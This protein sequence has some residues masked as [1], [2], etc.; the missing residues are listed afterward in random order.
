MRLAALSQ[1]VQ[2]VREVAADEQ[3][4]LIDYERLMDEQSPEHIPGAS[5]FL[6]HVH[7][8]IEGNRLLALSLFDFLNERK[9][10][11]RPEPWDATVDRVVQRVER[12]I[13]RA[14]H[15]QALRNLAKVLSWAGKQ[16]EANQLALQASSMVGGDAETAYLAGN[17]LLEAGNTDD[18]IGKFLEAL[19]IDPNHVMSLNS[20]GSAYFRQGQFDTALQQ[21]QRVVELQ[22]DFS[23]VHNNLGALYEQRGETELAI[24]HYEEAIRLNPRYSKAYNNVAVLLRKQRRFDEAVSYLRKALAINPDFA[25]AHFNL[26]TI[27]DEQGDTTAAVDHYRR[28]VKLNPQYGPAYHRLG[29]HLQEQRQWRAAAQAFRQAIRPPTPSL[30]AARRLAWILATCPDPNLRNGRLAVEMAQGCV[31]ATQQQDPD[32]LSTLAAAY[33]EAGDFASATKWQTAA[34]QLAAPSDRAQHQLRLET[35]RSRKP[36]RT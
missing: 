27:S 7:P 3:V 17:A 9:I 12:G 1:T 5:L 6:D 8:T 2:I 26:G 34:L 21:Y 22:P 25:E 16:D 32:A 29:I 28:A 19:R 35:L 18:A 13:D 33:A 36:I 14:A 15:G 23:P 20:L 31:K 24:R 30:D 4:P 11:P 10:V